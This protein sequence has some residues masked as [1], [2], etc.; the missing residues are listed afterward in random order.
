M[1]RIGKKPITVPSGVEVRIQ[2][3]QV[4][5]KGPKGTLE[6]RLD[7][8]VHLTL[9]GDQLTVAVDRPEE[10]TSRELWGTSRV[11]L[12]NMVIGVTQGFTKQLEINGVGYRAQASGKKITLNLGYSHPIEYTVPQEIDV[13]VEKNVITIAG[14]NKQLVGH[15]AAQ[16][17]DFRKP[18]PYKG[19]GIKYI[20]E[21][22]RRK[23]GKVVKTAGAG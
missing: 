17:R 13:K 18:E 14:S 7:E 23:A 20:D 1:P 5:V 12:A 21:V 8:R 11:L 6:Q 10:K 3:T 9:A 22:I 16:I 19:K 2:G 15:I 4:S